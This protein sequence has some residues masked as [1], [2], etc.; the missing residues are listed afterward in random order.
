MRD[1]F[2][3]DRR[4]STVRSVVPRWNSGDHL[5]QRRSG[6]ASQSLAKGDNPDGIRAYAAAEAINFFEE[7]F[8]LLLLIA[9]ILAVWL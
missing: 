5:E 7:A 1:G 6:R 2:S 8:L 4:L 3:N 9:F